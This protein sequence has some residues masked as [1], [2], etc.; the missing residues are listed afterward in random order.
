MSSA[1]QVASEVSAIDWHVVGSAVGVG[2]AAVVT[3][4]WGWL[5]GEG[6]AKKKHEGHIKAEGTDLQVA[7]AVLQ[8]NQSLRENTQAVRD[9]RDQVM[10]L[11]HTEERKTRVEE[12]LVNVLEDVKELLRHIQKTV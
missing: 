9:L 3:G 5:R 2:I 10:L 8:D 7:G 12:E 11:I 6:K 4:V 1:S